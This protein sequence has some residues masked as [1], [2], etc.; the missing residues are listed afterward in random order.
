MAVIIISHVMSHASCHFTFAFVISLISATC[1]LY[2]SIFV[3]NDLSSQYF[4]YS[5]RAVGFLSCFF[6][7][8]LTVLLHFW[9]WCVPLRICLPELGWF[10]NSDPPASLFASSLILETIIALCLLT[11]SASH[12]LTSSL[13]HVGCQRWHSYAEQGI[14]KKKTKTKLCLI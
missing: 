10:P 14:V 3:S 11:V 8:F 12:F 4:Q 13:P 5:G 2:F 1:Y 7:D 9:C 6:F